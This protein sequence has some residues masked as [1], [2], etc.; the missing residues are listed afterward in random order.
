MATAK[1]PSGT[2]KAKKKTEKKEKAKERIE[3]SPVVKFYKGKYFE[4]WNEKSQKKYDKK[5][6]DKKVKEAAKTTKKREKQA[7]S[8]VSPEGVKRPKGTLKKQNKKEKRDK[9]WNSVEEKAKPLTQSVD[10][11]SDRFADTIVYFGGTDAHGGGEKLRDGSGLSRDI[12]S[13]KKK[14]KRA[15]EKTVEK[16]GSSLK[17]GF[18]ETTGLKLKGKKR[19]PSKKGR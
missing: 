6:E 8:L 13:L 12:K 17:K 5:Q 16:A 14:T 19:T 18:E 3:K 1:R 10:K 2:M 15:V 4:N 9:F 7:S 11:M